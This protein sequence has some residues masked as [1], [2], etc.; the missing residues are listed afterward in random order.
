MKRRVSLLLLLLV[1]VLTACIQPHSSDPGQQLQLYFLSTKNHGPAIVGEPYS[2][3]E[4][5]T[6]EQLIAA[7][8]AGPQDEALRSPFP[9][10]LALRGLSLNEGHLTV[11]FSE[12]Y[13]G[14]ADVSLTLADYCVVLTV[15]QLDEVDSVEITVSGRSMVYRS[16]PVLTPDEVAL[17]VQI[18]SETEAS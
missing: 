5:P 2:G 18:A 15:C 11:D 7:L 14:L 10:G 16:H 1:A 17:D 4:Q 12:P 13:G 8:L 6:V 9:S 3:Q